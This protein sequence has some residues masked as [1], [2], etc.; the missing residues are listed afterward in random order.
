MKE[1]LSPAYPK[2]KKIFLN[3]HTVHGVEIDICPLSG[4]IWF[5]RFELKK[6]DEQKEPLEEI[7]ALLPKNPIPAEIL[8]NRKS[9]LHPE[10]TMQQ[11]PYGPK[12]TNGV[13]IVDI[14]PV[15]AGIWLDYNE[16]QKIRE[17]YPTESEMK[18][19]SEELVNNAF[20]NLK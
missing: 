15:C 10:A 6:F 3:A 20:Q 5:N 9:P 19:L 11:R 7:L 4:G 13:L 2:E 16:L 12:G 17:L 18:K 1:L 8:K 14:C